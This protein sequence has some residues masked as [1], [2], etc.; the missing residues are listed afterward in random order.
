MGPEREICGPFLSEVNK[1][2]LLRRYGQQVRF[3]VSLAEISR[4]KIGGLA[5]VVISPRNTEE[6]A[7]LR[8]WIHERGLPSVVIGATSNLLFAD[9]GLRAIAIQIGQDFSPLKISGREIVAGP[10]VWVP[11]LALK[12]MRVGLTG[13]EHTCG[14]PGTLGGLVYMNGG[15]QRKG[16]GNTVS[17]VESID[18]LG[19]KVRRSREECQFAYR[20]SV[21]QNLDEV[22][23]EIGLVLSD[24]HDKQTVRASML[25]ILRDRRKKFPQ[26]LPNCG[27]VF[28]SNPAMYEKYGT[29]GK[30]IE[31]S[32]CKNMQ[33]GDAVI[34]D[35][36][37]NFIVN[38][39]IASSADVIK[40]IVTVR[41]RVEEMT[42]YR[43]QV[44]AKYVEASGS[45]IDMS[46]FSL[47]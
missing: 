33:V 32:G 17:Y 40:L 20:S 47:R 14:I 13:M 31:A 4:W 10:G 23:S 26:K 5:D 36:H 34:S 46:C 44:E 24:A 42:G 29:P 18:S 30:V 37:A 21:F 35:M 19:N 3:D 6:L 11:G 12:A 8:T 7:G 15:S 9:E 28:V 38:K 41:N 2:D 22:I 16:I 25:A 43:M 39:G 1:Q 45:I 27:S